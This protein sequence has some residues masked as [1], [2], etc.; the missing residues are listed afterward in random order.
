MTYNAAIVATWAI[1]AMCFLGL[2]VLWPEPEPEPAPPPEPAKQI[3]INL[4]LTKPA[5]GA[6]LNAFLRFG[7]GGPINDYECRVNGSE[8]QL[9]GPAWDEYAQHPD[10]S[11]PKKL[12]GAVEMQTEQAVG[13]D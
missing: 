1:S 3:T 9:F 7:Q 5:L 2:L 13:H 8:V 11:P 10:G 4:D 12:L 6:C